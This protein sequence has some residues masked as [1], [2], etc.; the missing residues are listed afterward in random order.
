MRNN[1][2]NLILASL[3]RSRVTRSSWDLLA[4]GIVE[5]LAIFSISTEMDDTLNM[6]LISSNVIDELNFKKTL[7]ISVALLAQDRSI[8]D[9]VISVS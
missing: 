9:S 4:N 2:A 5:D 7:L 8:I 1:F 3:I 6:P